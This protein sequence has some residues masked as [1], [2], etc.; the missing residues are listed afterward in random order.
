MSEP[1]L[2][3]VLARAEGLDA[4]GGATWTRDGDRGWVLRTVDADGLVDSIAYRHESAAVPQSVVPG[5]SRTDPWL[6]LAVVIAARVEGCGVEV[7]RG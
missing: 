2:L 1:D 7:I 4:S 5:M 3:A 6:S